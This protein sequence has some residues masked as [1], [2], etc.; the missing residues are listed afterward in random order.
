MK[1]LLRRLLLSFGLFG[2][3]K[4]VRSYFFPDAFNKKYRKFKKYVVEIDNIKIVY[5]TTDKYSKKWF[6]PRYDDGKIHEPMATRLFIQHIN[7]Q[8]CVFDIG[9]HL[10]YF[11]CLAGMLTSRG[12]VHAFEVDPKCIP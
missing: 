6:Y 3:A 2:Y 4:R 5:D 12:E 7:K 8:D 10:G 11:T 1:N 9:S